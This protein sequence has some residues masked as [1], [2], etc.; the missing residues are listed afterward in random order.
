LLH[1]P[2]L[3]HLEHGALALG[4]DDAHIDLLHALGLQ[5]HAAGAAGLARL[6]RVKAVERLGKTQGQ[7]AP[8]HPR[9]PG[10]QVGMAGFAALNMPRQQAFR[11]FVTDHIPGHRLIVPMIG[12]MSACMS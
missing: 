2:H 5:A 12:E 10:K 11:P 8:S 7:R 3:L 1:L 4:L 9:R 6:G